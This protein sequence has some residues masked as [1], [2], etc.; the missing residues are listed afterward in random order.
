MNTTEQ[1]AWLNARCPDGGLL[2]SEGWRAFQEHE[3]RHTEHYEGEGWR[4]NAIE[5][6]LPL[7]GTYWYMPRGP[8]MSE[9]PTVKHEELGKQE[10]AKLLDEAKEK[11]RG[12]VRVEPKNDEELDLLRAWS[13]PYSCKKAPHD[14]QP[15][16][17][18]VADIA[19]DDDTIFAN[20]KPKTR[21]NIRLAERRG[22]NVSSNRDEL[23]ISDFLRMNRETARRNRISTHPDRHYRA[24]LESFPREQLELFTATHEGRTLAAILVALFGDTATYLHGASGDDDRGLMAPYLLQWHAMTASRQR[25][26]V[27]Y[28]FGG[29]DTMGTA[30]GLSGV[31]RFKLGFSQNVKTIRYPGSYDIV[32]LPSIYMLYKAISMSK[33]AVKRAIRNLTKK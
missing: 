15:R 24:L 23:S 4:M 8:V 26:C 1:T 22:V 31:T 7:T 3:G 27:R 12:W 5:H 17:I 20:M 18:F 2:Q 32:L 9:E 30:P 13:S 25:G 14:M 11:G 16:E 6:T 33:Y 19:G 10:W 29:V 21:Y 28:D